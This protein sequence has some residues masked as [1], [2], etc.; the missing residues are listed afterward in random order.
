MADAQG[1][2]NW[3]G[4]LT[5]GGLLL[6]CFGFL[7]A[8]F[9][10]AD[11]G[12]SGWHAPSG[13]P[14]IGIVEVDGVITDSK[15]EVA[16][17]HELRKDPNVKAIVVRLNTPGG[18]VAPSQEIFQ[19]VVRARKSKKVICSMGTVAA[20]GGY[21]IASACDRIL[22]SPGTITGSIGVISQTPHVQGLLELMRVEMETVKS[23]ALKDMES[24]F[25]A[26]TPDERKFVQGFVDGIY[27]QFL[28]DV[29]QMRKI[30]KEKLRPIADGRILSGKEALAANLVDELGNFEDA[31]DAAVK[32]AGLTGEPVPDFPHKKG[33]WLSEMVRSTSES[34]APRRTIEMR[35]PRL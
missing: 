2:S 20:S 32:L 33:T 21:Y 9:S 14:H 3:A 15:D 24:P 31:L 19:A 27:D 1:R 10:S 25:R 35:D 7:F 12:E 22:A 11:L 23:G 13:S 5:F 28:S 16:R 34:L 17:L 18:A 6:L 8:L 29:A 26:V 4:I 30:D